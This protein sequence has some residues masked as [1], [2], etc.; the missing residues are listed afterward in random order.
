VL[1][2]DRLILTDLRLRSGTVV[3]A[4]SR[5]NEDSY[6]SQQW[7]NGAFTAELLAALASGD[8]DVDGDGALSIEELVGHVTAAVATRTLDLQHPYLSQDN[9]DAAIRLPLAR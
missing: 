9:I 1:D 8:A 5:W 7:G 2:R 3:L 6:E 4:A